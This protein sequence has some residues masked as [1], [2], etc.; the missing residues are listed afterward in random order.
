MS[1]KLHNK[2]SNLFFILNK[3][4]K[5]KGISI[6]IDNDL[7]CQHLSF[8][9]IKL[10]KRLIVILITFIEAIMFFG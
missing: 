5:N 7:N 8:L 6:L 10:I 4:M 2:Q 1:D 9:K 3:N